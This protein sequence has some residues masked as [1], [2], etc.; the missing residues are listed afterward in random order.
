M[1]LLTCIVLE[2]RTEQMGQGTETEIAT[3]I[4]TMRGK[5]KREIERE[6]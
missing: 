2:K 5:K 4:E 1:A 6:E 3:D